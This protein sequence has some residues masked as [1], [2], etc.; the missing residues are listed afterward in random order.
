V[1]LLGVTTEVEGIKWV[2]TGTT[3]VVGLLD[4]IGGASKKLVEGIGCG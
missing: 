4:V 1:V 2:L 3:V